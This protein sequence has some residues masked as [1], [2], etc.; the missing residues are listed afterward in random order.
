MSRQELYKT[1]CECEV[2]EHVIS[3]ECKN[4]QTHTYDEIYNANLIINPDKNVPISICIPDRWQQSLVDIY[5]QNYEE[6]IFLPH[7]EKNGKLCLF[8]LEGV[9]IDTNLPGILIQ[10]VMRA[11]TILEEGLL[12]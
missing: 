7:V 12:C 3:S 10:S 9:L 8:E 2:L 11:K 1:L 5:V 6:M 4:F